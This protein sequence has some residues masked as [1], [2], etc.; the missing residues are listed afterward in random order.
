M[1]KKQRK[2][3]TRDK[4]QLGGLVK[5]A[6]LGD[7]ATALL[8]GMLVEAREAL[9]GPDGELTRRRWQRRGAAIFDAEGAGEPN[10]R[11]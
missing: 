11:K 1:I 8:L 2:V 7:E 6:R 3:D 5:K 10:R 9:D 4:I